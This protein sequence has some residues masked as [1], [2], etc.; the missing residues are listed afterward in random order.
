MR[1]WSGEDSV[2]AASFGSV[3]PAEAIADY[4]QSEAGFP[5]RLEGDWSVAIWDSRLRELTCARDALG[6]LPFCYSLQGEELHF[7]RRVRDLLR[8]PSISRDIDEGVVARYLAGSGPGVD[9][10]LFRDIRVLPGGHRLAFDANGGLRV[11]R[12]WK[13]TPDVLRL[14]SDAEYESE[15]RRLLTES[16]QR[17]LPSGRMGCHLSG[18]LDSSA[19]SVLAHRTAGERGAGPVS[20]FSQG[21]AGAPWDE[22][23][24]IAEI[25][26][27]AG[28][29]SRIFP[30]GD[31]LDYTVQAAAYFLDF[32]SYPN[33]GIAELEMVRAARE[34]GIGVMLTGMGGNQALERGAAHMEEWGA[35]FQWGKAIREIQT[36]RRGYGMPPARLEPLWRLAIRPNLVRLLPQGLRRAPNLGAASEALA[37]RCHLADRLAPDHAEPFGSIQQMRQF[38]TLIGA[39]EAQPRNVIGWEGTGYGVDLVHPFHD[40]RL[41]EFCLRLPLDQLWRDG[42]WKSIHRRAMKGLLPE[43]VLN[44]RVQAEF[45][46]H[47]RRLLA[48]PFARERLR[49]LRMMRETDWLDP[50][51][52]AK[53]IEDAD[54]LV[55]S[56]GW[57]RPI[58]LAWNI[59]AL[60]LWF[61]AVQ[62]GKWTDVHPMD[63]I[64]SKPRG[65][66]TI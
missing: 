57:G 15:Y 41:V 24:Y 60:D 26:R 6:N 56:G 38:N 19:V 52:T 23:S 32:P 7:A 42:M 2:F 25:G 9:E 1:L 3:K 20:T 58:R 51:R 53:I 65:A 35:K 66:A 36:A 5:T 59:F 8:F 33:G 64:L 50:K 17:R 13:P 44:R 18:G 48:K 11:Q 21:K 12:W 46:D 16:I 28:L 29:D 27:L 40:R 4:R 49:N 22:S 10:T 37:R 47:Y 30:P 43:S 63:Y 14:K 31:D 54:A 62:S 45:S 61:D 55:A 34:L 39:R